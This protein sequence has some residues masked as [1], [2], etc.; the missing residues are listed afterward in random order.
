MKRTS[1]VAGLILLS[2]SLLA[3]AEDASV[4]F[5]VIVHPGVG[6]AKIPRDTLA[7]IYLGKARTWGDGSPIA[8]VDLSTVSPVR[9][10][11]SSSVLKRS[12]DGVKQYWMHN[13][14]ATNRPPVVK[15]TDAAVIAFVAASAGGV[16]YVAETTEVP[17]TVRVVSLQ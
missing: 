1:F 8:A 14:T 2:S 13:M 4:A 9:R 5:K 17:A 15:E 10:S 11:F 3:P 16:G 12:V 6:G 7:Q